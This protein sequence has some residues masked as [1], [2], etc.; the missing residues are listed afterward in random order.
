MTCCMACVSSLA[1]MSR[2]GAG[3][4]G[5]RTQTAG[6]LATGDA[7]AGAGRVACPGPGVAAPPF[8]PKDAGIGRSA[9]AP[10]TMSIEYALVS[11]CT[12]VLLSDGCLQRRAIAKSKT[13][14][15]NR[16]GCGCTHMHTRPQEAMPTA[17]AAIWTPTSG[18]CTSPRDIRTVH[19]N[20]V[21]Q[22]R[23]LGA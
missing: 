20:L 3:G 10:A 17:R 19:T 7:P 4:T 6:R 16:Y 8:S 14:Q 18:M 23:R 1:V 22:H 5:A 13:Y 15:L 12:D 11:M 2:P 21:K 9:D